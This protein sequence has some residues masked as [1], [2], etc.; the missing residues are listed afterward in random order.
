[1]CATFCTPHWSKQHM[2]MK[3][4]KVVVMHFDAGEITRPPTPP[5]ASAVKGILSSL[6]RGNLLDVSDCLRSKLTVCKKDQLTVLS[7]QGIKE[8]KSRVREWVAK[9]LPLAKSGVWGCVETRTQ[10][11][12][13]EDVHI[14]PGHHRLTVSLVMQIMSQVGRSSSIS[15][16]A[17]GRMIGGHASTQEIVLSSSNGDSTEW[18]RMRQDSRS[19]SGS[20]MLTNHD[21]L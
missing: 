5:D 6:S 4:N 8:R 19:M 18:R 17:R 11:S 20:R 16:I 3:I 15:L 21:Q 12:T 2:N 13:E 10:W 7:G 14:T 9:T 1:L